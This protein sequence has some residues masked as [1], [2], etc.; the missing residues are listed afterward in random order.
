MMTWPTARWVTLILVISAVLRIQGLGWDHWLN[1]HPDERNLVTAAQSLAFPGAMVP[2]FHAYNGLALILPKALAFAVCGPGPSIECVTWAAR[3]ISAL[4][5]IAAVLVGLRIAVRLAGEATALPAALLLSFSA[6]LIQWAHF[7]TTESALILT[8]LVLWLSS[9]RFLNGEDSVWRVSVVWGVTLGLGLGMK[10][11]AG[12]FALIPLFAVA[13]A[14]R[15]LDRRALPAALLCAV[16][17]LSLFVLTTP[18][19]IYAREDYFGVMRFEG[20]VVSG[21]ADVFWTW[22]F[23]H[24]TNLLYELSQF[25]RLMD[26]TAFLLAVVGIGLALRTHTRRSLPAL[27]LTLV[28]LALVCF[29]HAKFTRYLSPVLP[30]LL[31]FAAIAAAKLFSLRA[32]L[33]FPATMTVMLVIAL[34]LPVLTG[35]STAISYRS[36]DPRVLAAE[37]LNTRIRPGDIVLVEPREVGVMGFDGAD[38]KVLPLTEPPGEAKLSQIADGLAAGDW[39]LIYSRRHWAVLPGLSDRFPELCAYY[40]ALARGDLGYTF[41]ANFKRRAP[42]GDLLEPDLGSE[43]TRTVFD[44]PTVYLLQNTSHLSAGNIRARL[45]APAGDCAPET[46]LTLFERHR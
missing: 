14:W 12:I 3:L 2:S 36:A 6:P 7:G 19:L 29:W 4:S 9:I 34:S 16:L 35:I 46:L 18:A 32:Q 41:V 23:T 15:R 43:E 28:Y 31:I 21:A 1:F 26:G 40:G 20:D 44:R 17:A 38:L 42:F 24:A 8:V 39:M 10:T 30:V 33:R 45:A 25:W 22:Q 37:R 11:T 5:A 27:A 13:L